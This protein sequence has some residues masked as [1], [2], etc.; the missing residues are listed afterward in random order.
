MQKR[1]LIGAD[2]SGF[3]WRREVNFHKLEK[4]K[5]IHMKL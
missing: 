3:C 1:Y 5:N 4:Q 2:K